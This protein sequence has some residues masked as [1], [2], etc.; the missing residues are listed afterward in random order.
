MHTVLIATV[1]RTQLR[2][3][4]LLLLV[5]AGA[6]VLGRL[7]ELLQ[8]ILALTLHELAHAAV[9]AVFGCRLRSVELYPFGGM[10]R[11]D[12]RS[13]SPDAEWCI[14]AA[15][16]AMSFIVAGVAALTCYISPRTGARIEPFLTFNLTLATVNLLPALPLDGGHIA[17]Y[18]LCE[19]MNARKAHR[20]SAWAG[21]VIGVAMALLA[22]VAAYRKTYNLTLPV[23]GVFLLFASIAEIRAAPERRLTELWQKEDAILHGCMD[24]H[25]VAA[26]T[27]M[28]GTE[29]LRLI[30]GNRYMFIRV[31]DA[32][33]RLM[34]ELDESSLLIGMVQLGS[35]TS[36]GEI[37]RESRGEGEESRSK[38]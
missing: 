20:L 4:P 2:I 32:H 7:Y 10:A 23:M 25:Y 9:A 28:R 38:S 37:L 13:I 14:A 11:L 3:H 1:G 33:M 29:A 17:R 22:G 5:L 36:I 34:G 19:K 24:V 18:I 21:I 6:C 12:A 8:A 30:R 27:S 16:P 15:G 26:H 35:D 31:V